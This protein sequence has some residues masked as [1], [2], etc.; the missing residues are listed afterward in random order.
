MKKVVLWQR[1]WQ[2]Q[3]WE[4]VKIL[5]YLSNGCILRCANNLDCF[6]ALAMA[7]SDSILDCS[8]RN[9]NKPHTCHCETFAGRK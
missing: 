6:A 7:E 1:S 9:G 2:S 4:V 8:A 5:W 3:I